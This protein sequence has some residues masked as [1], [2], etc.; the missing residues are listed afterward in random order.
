[1][2]EEIIR[3]RE[4]RKKRGIV[5]KVVD[6]KE[7]SLTESERQRYLSYRWDCR[8][9]LGGQNHFRT[10]SLFYEYIHRKGVNTDKIN[11]LQP[12]F[13][14]KEY[15]RG[16]CISLRQIYLAHEDPTEYFFAKEVFGSWDFWK[17]LRNCEVLRA[18]VEKWRSELEVRLRA[19]AFVNILRTADGKDKNAYDANKVIVKT[20]WKL[21][22]E[23]QAAYNNRGRPSKEEIREELERQAEFERQ[24]L[25][26]A[27]RAGI[28]LDIHQ[29]AETSDTNQETLI[30]SE[31]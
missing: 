12:V 21:P 22:Q 30:A 10:N 17:E 23:L 15:D 2:R 27:K 25:E 5:T 3:E 6:P 28:V 14:L 9:F 7:P 26:N 16:G 8:D 20:G 4:E 13:T 31:G 19:K 11:G 24:V 1:M 18:E 29:E